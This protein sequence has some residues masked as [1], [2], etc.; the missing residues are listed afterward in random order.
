MAEE[1]T[2]QRILNLPN[3]LSLFRLVLCVVFVVFMSID[4]QGWVWA[5]TWALAIFLIA[6]FT[7]WLDGYLARRLNQ[8]TDLGKLLDPLAD[9]ILVGAAF[10]ALVEHE[11]ISAWIVTTIIAR[12]FLV[13]GLRALAASKGVVVAADSA[14]KFKTVF[15]MAAIILGLILLSLKPFIQ[16]ADQET[17]R[18]IWAYGFDPMVYIALAATVYSGVAYYWN[19]RALVWHLPESD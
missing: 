12:E 10:I 5:P 2:P 16:E 7:D 14:G 9:K 3:Q 4:P 8:I 1:R 15:Q 6:S 11:V 19:N 17:I 13:T 18:L